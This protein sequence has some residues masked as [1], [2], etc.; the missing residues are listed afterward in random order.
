MQLTIPSPQE[1]MTPMDSKAPRLKEI[2][3]P[4]ALQQARDYGINLSLL[5]EDL[6]LSPYQRME[7][8]DE[9]VSEILH[10]QQKIFNRHR[11]L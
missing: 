9:A 6:R 5:E 3:L 8:H 7:R 4:D 2:T 10:L 1:I 11:T